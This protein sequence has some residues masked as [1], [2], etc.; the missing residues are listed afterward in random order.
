VSE[1]SE[2]GQ[3]SIVFLGRE[4]F[5]MQV[6]ADGVPQRV[7]DAPTERI[8]ERRR[9]SERRKQRG[10]ELEAPVGAPVEP[11]RTP[12][13]N[14]VLAISLGTFVCGALLATG[15]SRVRRHAAAP[16]VIAQ[17]EPI[18]S[19]AP[20]AATPRPAQPSVAPLTQPSPPAPTV[21]PL[22]KVEAA[23]APAPALLPPPAIDSRR[24]KRPAIAKVTPPAR[25]DLELA[26]RP[27]RAPTAKPARAI[28]PAPFDAA[29]A[30]KKPAGPRQ[31]VD[32][33]A[34]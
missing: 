11:W 4:S 15:V 32:P 17:A 3:A 34:E 18:R 23:P 10:I 22:P 9:T 14:R 21:E 20:G 19:F 6:V 16:T 33:F 12:T 31:W 26:A 2:T 30:K 28:E 25:G 5:R 8:I 24:E 1:S 27:R 13:W 7:W 29:P